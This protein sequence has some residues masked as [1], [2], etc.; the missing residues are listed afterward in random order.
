MP[1]A[2]TDAP[3]KTYTFLVRLRSTIVLWLPIALGVIFEWDW[4]LKLLIALLG[5][6]TAAEYLRMGRP[7]DGAKEFPRLGLGI[8]LCY[9]IAA[10]WYSVGLN[11]EP[12]WWLE[13]SALAVALMGSFLL[14]CRRELEGQTTLF[15]IFNTTFSTAYTTILFG[16]M[17]HIYC[18]PGVSGGRQL[19]LLVTMTTKFGDMGAYA[20]GSVFGRHKMIP[21]I[22]P[23]KTWEGFGGAMIGSFT[24]VIAMMLIVPGRLA[25]L[26]WSWALLLAPIICVVG[27][28]GDL[29]ES[30]LKR[31]HG[32]KDSG[33]KLPGIGGI[34]DLTDSLLFTGPVTYFYLKAIASLKHG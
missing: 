21:R 16:F 9:W 31:C 18:F 32:I 23:G 3:S 17:L 2:T 26:T 12:P 22:S 20:F 7:D 19:T 8:S 11:V 27:V 29:S 10:C 15:R 30:V 24:A 6:L 4:L 25:P 28:F 34:L 14:T 5:V 1:D 33:H 13:I